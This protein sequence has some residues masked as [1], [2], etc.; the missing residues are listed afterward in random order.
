MRKALAMGAHRG[1][2]VTDPALVGSCVVS[3][4]LVLAAALRELE[5]DLVLAGVDTSDGLAGVVPAAVAAHLRLPYL[6]AAARI[7]PDPAA[8]R[9]RVRRLSS[10]GY[11]LLEAPMPAM[12]ACTQ[13]LGEPRYPSL[14][15]IMAARSKEIVTRSL[16][17]LGLADGSVGGA[18][19]TTRLVDSQKPPA[20][21]AT[22]VVRAPAAEAARRIVALLAERRVI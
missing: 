21:G 20:R 16:A 14:K 11:D 15:G 4:A 6:S 7:E 5:F 3:T 1:V 17:D 10:T 2:H 19:A 18:V 9:V 22:E 13:V 12:I 8:G